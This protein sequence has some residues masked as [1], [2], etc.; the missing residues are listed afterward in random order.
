MHKLEMEAGMNTLEAELRTLR[1]AYDLLEEQTEH[2]GVVDKWSWQKLV[3]IGRRILDEVYPEHLFTGASG[4]TGPLYIVALRDALA[5]LDQ[6][7]STD[8]DAG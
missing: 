8:V 4:D 7:R 6:A 3:R 1:E 5:V 2:Y